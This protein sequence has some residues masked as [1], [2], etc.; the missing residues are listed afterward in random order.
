LFLRLKKLSG[1]NYFISLLILLG[2]TTTLV[3]S[4]FTIN[5]ILP[6]AL[7]DEPY[8]YEIN[9]VSY[10]EPWS[11]SV[12]NL[13]ATFPRGG[14]IMNINET[15]QFRTLILLGEGIFEQNGKRYENVETSGLLMMIEHELF[16]E[17]RG[18][19]IFMPV[20]E[21]S[22]LF[23]VTFI[24]SKQ[25]GVPNI[26]KDRIPLAFHG[27]S[28]LA[29]YYLLDPEGNPILPPKANLS[30]GEL[31]GTFIIYLLFILI[32]LLIMT[33]FS[34][35]HRYSRYWIHLA[36]IPP[37][38]FALL[39]VVAIIPAI[40]LSE[41]IPVITGQPIFFASVGYGLVLSSLVV[42]AKYG[43][44]NYLDLGLR[45]DR[46]RYGYGLVLITTAIIILSAHGLPTGFN[47]SGISTI[48]TLPVI[49]LLIGLPRE[50][51]W[52]GYIQAVLSRRFGVNRGLVIMVILASL[53]RFVYLVATEP[54]MITYP[55]TYLE[56]AILA[57]GLAAIL[58]YLY[59]RTE[60]ILAC[61]LLHSLLT[62]IPVII[63]Y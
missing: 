30:P 24:Y 3:I 15:D 7:G 26:W 20:E 13:Q 35:D 54:W 52:R 16:E 61:A 60:N 10:F 56:V 33:I 59:L 46:I 34:L 12:N 51:I 39:A 6:N 49:F 2:I 50:M 27:R 9:S 8:R 55:Y 21:Q 32:T 1:K 28:G 17:L 19:N 53:V 62:W 23:L 5:S 40:T 25:I 22:I 63:I 44:I 48:Y 57:P 18:S 4:L 42:A 45:R 43:K 47:L 29:F 38:R 36:T 58:G 41:I 31:Y 14:I 37:G 11:F